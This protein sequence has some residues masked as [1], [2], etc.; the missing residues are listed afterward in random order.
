[1]NRSLFVALVLLSACYIEPQGP[2]PAMGPPPQG[3]FGPM[4]G[5]PPPG[6]AM[7]AGGV[8]EAGCSYNATQLPGDVGAVFQVACP[9]GCE[10]SGSLWGTDIYT[11]DSGICRAGIHAGLITP[12]GGVVTV[13]IEPGQPAYRGSVR[14]GIQSSDYGQY[15]K[16]YVLFGSGQPAAGPPQNQYPPPPPNQYPAQGQYPPQ[17]QYP[18]AQAIEAGCS[19]S[20]NQIRGDI[21]SS[22]LVN[23]PP[24]CSSR[25][26]LWG[27]DIYTADSGVCRAAI[28]A[29][30]I[31][32]G[33]GNVVVTLD[34]G[35]PAYRGS[36]RNGVHSSDYGN[37]GK[38][39]HLQ[40]P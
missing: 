9:P 16:S 21:G 3:G 23:C 5:G 20:G 36:D 2:P 18:A 15:G 11:A 33:G 24:G 31:T 13:R 8:I 19:Y 22:H 26:G 35:R 37:Y 7:A 32:D 38:S 1:V 28:H 29:G 34:P 25:G 17:N 6:G 4:Q 40:R 10:A 14:Y 30:L 39:Y 12:G 27:T